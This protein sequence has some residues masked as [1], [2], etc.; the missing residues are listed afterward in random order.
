M[1][2]G[3]PRGRQVI[4]YHDFPAVNATLNG[5]SAVLLTIAYVAVKRRHYR[6]HGWTMAAALFSSVLFLTCYITYHTMKLQHGEGVTR[7]P[8]S[9]WKPVYSAILISHTILA[10][11]ILP[12]IGIS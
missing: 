2:S 1:G 5:L 12:M 6:A 9:S 3:Q 4:D 8:A 11:V 7:F 10:V